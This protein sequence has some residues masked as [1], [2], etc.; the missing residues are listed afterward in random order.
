MFEKW[1]SIGD[2]HSNFNNL[3]KIMRKIEEFPLHKL[4]FLGDYLED[5]G[6]NLGD[7]LDTFISIERPAVF[8]KG[9]HEEEFLNFYSK[10]GTDKIK[11][12]KILNYFGIGL[13]HIDWLKNNLVY[14]YEND[15]AFFSHAGI[16]DRKSLREQTKYDLLNSAFK[17]NLDHITSK[18]IIQGHIIMGSVKCFGNH[19]FVDTGCGLGG[20]LSALVFPELK[21]ISCNN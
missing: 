16:D 14:S 4:I 12:G 2:I 19:W 10:Y 1:I 15:T 6:K 20:H 11:R 18:F 7:V 13:D 21:I 8:L 9:N 5:H 17:E 3:S